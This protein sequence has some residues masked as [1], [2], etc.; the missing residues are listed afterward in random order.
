MEYA[1][2]FLNTRHVED[3]IIR[4]VSHAIMATRV[5]QKPK[6]LISR[7]L[8]DAD[9]MKLSDEQEYLSD[10]ERLRREWINY[11]KEQYSKEEFYKVSLNFFKTHHF[12]T[13]YGRKILKPKKDKTEEILLKKLHKN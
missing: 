4:K 10:I 2:K 6:D 3:S 13:E 1:E 11:G 5:P 7:I 9:L 8:C 12:H